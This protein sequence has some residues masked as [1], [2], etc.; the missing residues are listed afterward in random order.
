MI[1]IINPAKIS[2]TPTQ[3][4]PILIIF[5]L[6]V[7]VL[8]SFLT[9][10]LTVK[11]TDS[12]T[13]DSTGI[14]WRNPWEGQTSVDWQSI[15]SIKTYHLLSLRGILVKSAIIKKRIIGL[16]SYLYDFPSILDRVREYA[17]EDHPLTIALE[18]EVSL[19]R[20]KPVR[21]LWWTL[22]GITICLSIWLIGGNLYADYQE[23]PL[24][25]AISNY[26][27]QH[28]KTAPNQSAIDLQASIVK[29]GLSVGNFGDGS[30]VTIQPDKKAIEEWK[31]IEPTLT[32]Y[33]ELDDELAKTEDSFTPIPAKLREYLNRHRSDIDLIESQLINGELPLWG[34]DSSWIEQTHPNHKDRS[35]PANIAYLDLYQTQKLLTLNIL[36]RKQLSDVNTF[37]NLHSIERL[38]ISLQNQTNIAAQIF[39]RFT[40]ARINK[41]V[42]RFEIVPDSF[43]IKPPNRDQIMQSAIEYYSLT[44][45][46]INQEPK[47][48]IGE[49]SGL[50]SSI[51][52]N[53]HQLFRPLTRLVSVYVQQED[54]RNLLYWSKQ[55]ICRLHARNSLDY[56]AISEYAQMKVGDLDRE[57]TSSIR[58]IKSQLRAGYSSGSVAN[59]FSLPSQ[60]CPG[61]QWTASIKDEAVV[62][63]FSHQPNW[64]ALEMRKD[65]ID[66]LTYRIDP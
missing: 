15:D 51:I 7:F 10:Y 29:L 2:T 42:R 57:L 32:K 17:G 22:G 21:G 3:N 39:S 19:P 38:N 18:K 62:I 53:H 50:I 64:K 58:Q 20:Q 49:E 31:A 23:Q 60:V 5:T 16:D 9:A 36:D 8:A 46:R 6:S 41:L 24:N 1:E 40:Q 54:R 43:E 11:V 55:N 35:I 56:Y 28:P 65:N 37:K 30:K 66:R 59:R 45:A 34:T 26:V 63:G 4:L 61:E 25:Q 48:L 13:V 44:K 33:L 12:I 14:S 47:S 27:R 52:L